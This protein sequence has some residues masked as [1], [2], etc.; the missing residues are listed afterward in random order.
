MTKV[1]KVE[2]ICFLVLKF[3]G[4]F[5]GTA[6][7]LSVF[8]LAGSFES[9]TITATQFWLYELCAFG[10][11]ALAFVVYYIREVVREDFIR[12]DSYLPYNR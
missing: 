5:C 10:L 4:Y 7:I 9:N 11:I 12:R 8:G 3:F 6:G 1:M 2:L